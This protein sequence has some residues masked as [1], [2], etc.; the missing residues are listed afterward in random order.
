MALPKKA[1]ISA[2]LLLTVAIGGVFYL[3]RSE[4]NASTQSTDDAYV[5]ADFTTVAP[6]VSGTIETVFVEDNQPVK[7]G[8]LLALI[9]DRDFVA[10]VNVA[11]AQ[12]ASAQAGIA[13]LQARLIQQQTVIR[14]A[15]AAVAADDAAL[16]LAKVNHTRYRNLA[17]DGSGTV[18]AQ[19]QAEAQLSVQQA[20]LEK[21]QAAL[22]AARQ[23]VD[24]LKADLDQARATLAH[25]QAAQA[26][27]ELKL[28]Y[29]RITAP[30][31]GTIGEKS[32]RVGAFVNAGKPLLA[33]VPLDAVYITANFRETQLARVQ[34]GQA[35]DIEV[36]ALPG[37][38]L[39]GTVQSL[40][41]ASGVSYSAIAPHNAT[42]N[43]TKIV[44]RLPVRI[45]IE[46]DQPATAKLRVGMSVTPHIRIRG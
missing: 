6:Q 3:N 13:N 15:Q 24:I 43:F 42:G 8:D 23:Q 25:A 18:Q 39:T 4:S 40:G 19:Q 41:P 38:T 7:K 34:T 20:G 9:D 22:Q 46:P 44:Q 28:S 36:D 10:S 37:E 35:V 11:K 5:H 21:S 14:Q 26:I 29:T 30:I 31:N 32:V 16:K 12:V 33:I 45:R 27:A 17:A 1:R 2:T